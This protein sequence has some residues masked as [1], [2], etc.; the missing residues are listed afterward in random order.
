ME[1]F[2]TFSNSRFSSFLTDL[3]I[4]LQSSFRLNELLLISSS[5]RRSQCYLRHSRCAKHL[6]LCRDVGTIKLLPIFL[7]L[8]NPMEY[9]VKRQT[10]EKIPTIHFNPSSLFQLDIYPLSLKWQERTETPDKPW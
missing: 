7:K 10:I 9:Y 6:M 8:V 1:A 2:T 3:Y 5:F 4:Y